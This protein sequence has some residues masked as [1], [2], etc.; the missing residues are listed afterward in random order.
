MYQPWP[1]SLGLRLVRNNWIYYGNA[2]FCPYTFWLSCVKLVRG[3]GI[4]QISV[5]SLFNI[6]QQN[7]E[8]STSFKKHAFYRGFLQDTRYVCLLWHIQYMA[9]S[10]SQYRFI[11]SFIVFLWKLNDR[12]FSLKYSRVPR[13]RVR[14]EL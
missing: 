11:F 4:V 12:I 9:I 5:I 2:R 3:H 13:L 14:F 8:K 6:R 7:P 10:S 1:D